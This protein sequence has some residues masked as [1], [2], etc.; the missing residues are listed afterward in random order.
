MNATMK[1]TGRF[2]LVLGALA[3]VFALLL[4]LAPPAAAQHTGTGMIPTSGGGG[5]TVTAADLLYLQ[6]DGGNDM[7]AGLTLAAGSA[8]APAAHFVG[9]TTTGLYLDTAAI[10]FAHA[11][12]Q[13]WSM[14][15]G[16]LLGPSGSAAAPAYSFLLDA[17]SGMYSYGANS[18][19]F[20]TGGVNRGGLGSSG[21]W[22]EGPGGTNYT[23]FTAYQR[24]SG[25]PRNYVSIY[26]TGPTYVASGGIPQD[27]NALFSNGAGGFS[28]TSTNAA[29]EIRFYRGATPDLISTINATGFHPGSDASLN[30]GTS[31]LSWDT[32]YAKT[33]ADTAGT[34]RFTALESAVTTLTST[35]PV[36]AGADEAFRLNITTNFAVTTDRVFTIYDNTGA[37]PAEVWAINGSGGT[38]TGPGSSTDMAI[39]PVSSENSGI[40][41]PSTTGGY[42]VYLYAA[43]TAML[44][45]N[46][47]S[48]YV[49]LV[50][51]DLRTSG[52]AF[53]TTSLASTGL[54]VYSAVDG[55]VGGETAITVGTSDNTGWVA[56]TLLLRVA[57]D[58][59]GTPDAWFTVDTEGDGIFDGDLTVSGNDITVGTVATIGA[60]GIQTDGDLTVDGGNVGIGGAA[61]A[62]ASLALQGTLGDGSGLVVGL[63]QTTTIDSSD[64]AVGISVNSTLDPGGTKRA[65][66]GLFGANYVA[67]TAATHAGA[68]GVE[69]STITKTGLGTFTEAIGLDVAVPTAGTDNLAIRVI[70]GGVKFQVIEGT[71]PAATVTCAIFY[72]GTMI[73]VDDTNDTVPG[74]MCMCGKGADDATYAWTRVNSPTT[75]CF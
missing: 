24:V 13:T 12:A 50:A 62:A 36:T 58:V 26:S 16:T 68:V 25:T 41:F 22:A 74:F 31:A 32:L 14:G 57:T 7:A 17:D 38:R 72:Q 67:D 42:N 11:G 30:L 6:V 10:G 23:G 53:Y 70:G 61:S 5:L 8:A 60:T 43:G 29:G 59:D 27:G 64:I 39:G 65:V 56:D 71:V 47:T 18:L 51:N 45:T 15:A 44:Q 55:N 33:I 20:A 52:S 73:Y 3:A 9:A 28:I 69:I 2:A 34:A 66:G 4:L 37:T 40:Y 48:G 49:S 75:A 46:V 54:S 1:S 21:W 63:S 19:G 35:T